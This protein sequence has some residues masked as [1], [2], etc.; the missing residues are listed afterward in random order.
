MGSNKGKS[1]Y[2]SCDSCGKEQ[3]RTSCDDWLMNHIHFADADIDFLTCEKCKNISIMDHQQKI[4]DVYNQN[5]M[6]VN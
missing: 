2:C 4:F 3:L 6:D 1:L 5:K